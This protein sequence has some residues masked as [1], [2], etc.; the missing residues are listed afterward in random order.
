[1]PKVEVSSQAA[2]AIAQEY[3]RELREKLRASEEEAQRTFW[4]QHWLKV[5]FAGVLVV[6][7]GIGYW[8]YQSTLSRN[9][10]RTLRDDLARAH[11][12]LNLDTRPGYEEALS[13]LNRAL[14]MDGSSV[15]AFGLLAYTHALLYEDFGHSP[16]HHKSSSLALT[17]VGVKDT[18]PGLSLVAQYYLTP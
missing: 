15:E 14:D 5:A 12:A 13:A 17:R 10:N 7:L 9:Q 11:K 6:G 1:M 2:L 16:D 3:E 8:A 4:A 18:F